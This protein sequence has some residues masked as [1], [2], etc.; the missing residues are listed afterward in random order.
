MIVPCYALFDRHF[1]SV[2]EPVILQRKIGKELSLNISIYY[3][4][5]YLICLTCCRHKC[6]LGKRC[7]VNRYII[8]QTLSN[9]SS[10]QKALPSLKCINQTVCSCLTPIFLYSFSKET[11]KQFLK[12]F[13]PGFAE[14][15]VLAVGCRH[16][17]CLCSYKWSTT[18]NVN[19]KTKL[20]E[21]PECLS[22]FLF[23][24]LS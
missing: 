23:L 10:N 8:R 21:Y 11:R 15:K 3:D 4:V 14:I 22:Q 19:T 17:I 6:L 5:S 7:I 13:Q 24:V 9:V 2:F 12:D 1:T 20:L 16:A 18:A